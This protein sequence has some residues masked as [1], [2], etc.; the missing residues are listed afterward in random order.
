MEVAAAML[1]SITVPVNAALLAVAVHA[2]SAVVNADI[3]DALLAGDDAYTQSQV[4]LPRRMRHTVN[5]RKKPRLQD[6][7]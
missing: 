5:T 7:K 3:T 6:G 2:A 4:L 1:A